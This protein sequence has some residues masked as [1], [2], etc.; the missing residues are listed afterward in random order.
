MSSSDRLTVSLQENMLTLLAFDTPAALLIRNSV[1]IAQWGNA[2][3][4]E[5]ATRIYDYLD[6]YHEAPADHTPDL[7]EDRLTSNTPEAQLFND[8]L[9]AI[10]EYR[11]KVNRKYTL[12][13]LET[14]VRTQSLTTTVIRAGEALQENQLEQVET[15][16]SEGLR[17]RLTMFQPGLRLKDAVHAAF[18]KQVRH[19]VLTLGIKQLD[20]W[21]LGCGDGELQLYAAGPKTGKSWWLVHNTKRCL[22]VN[23]PVLYVTLELSELQIL[24]RIMQALFSMTRRKAKVPVTRIRTDDL[25]RLVRFEPDMLGGRLSFDDPQAEQIVERKL[26]A[27]HGSENL[28][29]K[30]FPSGQLTVNKLAGYLDL[31]ERSENFVPRKIV[32]DYVKYMKH[33]T[34]NYRIDRGDILNNLRGLAVERNIGIITAAELNR[35]G[36]KSKQS[37]ATDMGEDFS[38]AYTADTILTYTQTAAEEKLGLARLFVDSSRVADRDKFVVLLSQC[39]DVGQYVLDSV[40][41]S[42]TYWG[43]LETAAA[44]AVEVTP[45]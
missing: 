44:N 1:E 36:A 6:K 13:Q 41:M 15:I 43:H 21:D 42:D 39:Y 3:Y 14:F 24:Q 26:G 7:L 38:G 27:V 22:L 25:G 30:Q 11:P 31:L 20:D 16:L 4:R 19:N 10:E 45:E 2:I 32:L 34:A 29:V 40:A 9:I 12:D 18:T 33:D 28:I 35:E 37:R 5:T 8:L 17:Q 23:E